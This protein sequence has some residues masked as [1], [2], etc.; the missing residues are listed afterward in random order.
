MEVKRRDWVCWLRPLTL[1]LRLR[2]AEDELKDMLCYTPSVTLIIEHGIL[3][4]DALCLHVT[5]SV[6]D[7]LGSAPPQAEERS[8]GISGR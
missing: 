2:G 8:S 3:Y 7:L 1:G 6:L 5:V 4:V